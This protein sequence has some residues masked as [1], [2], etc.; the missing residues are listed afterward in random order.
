MLAIAGSGTNLLARIPS[1]SYAT[2]LALLGN[3]LYA[4]G[5]FDIAGGKQARYITIWHEPQPNLSSGFIPNNG[6]VISWN[7][8]LN[9][10]YGV[11][12]AS[13]LSQ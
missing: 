4:S 13:D 8:E 2:A 7:S 11:Y 6:F 9:Q 12:P 3:V 5:G 10:T 1:G